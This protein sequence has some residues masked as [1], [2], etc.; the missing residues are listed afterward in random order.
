[1][2]QPM[3]EIARDT[4]VQFLAVVC[5]RDHLWCLPSI[6]RSPLLECRAV[7]LPFQIREGLVIAVTNLGAGAE[8]VVLPALQV[9]S[10]LVHVHRVLPSSRRT[11]LP[12]A[13][14]GFTLFIF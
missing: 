6:E 1:D 10:L 5:D 2:E 7:I 12:T 8:H 14:R 13:A 11:R 3:D 4:P 9:R